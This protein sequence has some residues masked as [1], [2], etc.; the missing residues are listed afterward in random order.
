MDIFEDF[1]EVFP[2]SI[3]PRRRF[4]AKFRV[5]SVAS[6]GNKEHLETGG[7]ILMPPSSVQALSELYIANPWIFCLT[8]PKNGLRTHCGVLEF[9]ADEGRFM[10]NLQLLAGQ[11]VELYSVSLPDARFAKFQPQSVD[12]LNI[13][14]PRAILEKALRSYACLTVGDIISISYGEKEDLN[15]EV[16]FEPPVGYVEETPI[17]RQEKLLEESAQKVEELIQQAIS[18]QSESVEDK[19]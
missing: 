9:T 2:H 5:R 8:N 17:T 19:V 18:D 15:S 7:R 10:T 12:F 1:L 3:H 13:T 6:L 4:Y 11:I 14:N 16:D